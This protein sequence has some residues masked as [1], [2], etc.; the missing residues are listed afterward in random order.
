MA[1][2]RT[3]R[4][5]VEV[6]PASH[7]SELGKSELIPARSSLADSPEEFS[8]DDDDRG[9]RMARKLLGEMGRGEIRTEVADCALIGR[10][11]SRGGGVRLYPRFGTA[12][13]EGQ[14]RPTEVSAVRQH[15]RC[16][17]V[18]GLVPTCGRP[19][20]RTVGELALKSGVRSIGD[21]DIDLTDAAD[22]AEQLRDRIYGLVIPQLAMG[23]SKARN[24]TNPNKNDISLTYEMA[25]TVLFRLLFISYAED[26]DFL[27]YKNNE[28]D[29]K[30]SSRLQGHPSTDKGL[31]GI[32][33]ASGSLGQGLS[34]GIGNAQVKKLNGDKQLVYT[35]HGDGELQEGQIWE[36]AMYAAFHKVD[37]LI[38]TID[39]NGRQ[40]DGDV[41]DVMSL[42]DLKLKWQAFGWEVLVMNGHDYENMKDT[43]SQAKELTGNGKPIVILMKTEMGMG[44]DFM[45]GTHKWH[46]VAPNPEQLQSALSQ[47][48][49]TLGDF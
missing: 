39:F 20:Q 42:G 48:E 44:V 10:D 13:P 26:R 24:L 30:I 2:V 23:I 34:V 16:Q 3:S 32:R 31:P 7:S 33:M 9:S 27:P 29:R 11:Q 36:A 18:M 40:I 14:I 4:R 6:D 47:L 17:Q 35:L 15:F 45:M 28:N 21:G 41:D 5:G 19:I 22:I 1:S 38:A 25:V 37:N 12:E 8:V 49:E 43:L 46:G